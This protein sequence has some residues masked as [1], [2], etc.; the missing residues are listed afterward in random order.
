MHIAIP[1][2]LQD[3]H[4][5][6]THE[7]KANYPLAATP[8][9][10]ANPPATPEYKATASPTP[11]YKAIPS[12]TPEYKAICSCRVELTEKLSACFKRVAKYLRQ[13][14]ALTDDQCQTIIGIQNSQDGAEKLMEFIIVDIRDPDTTMDSF[15]CFVAA[16]KQSGNRFFLDFVK[17][18]IEAK[19]KKFYRELLHVP[20][21]T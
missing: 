11:K 6:A 8:E 20:P 14:G 9:Y 21:G 2:S 17:D 15:D 7:Y 13:S 3:L 10:K 5:P 18:K 19:R 12:A 16:I 1:P 4:H